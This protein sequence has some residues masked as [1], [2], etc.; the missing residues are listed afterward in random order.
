[1]DA[2]KPTIRRYVLRAV[3]SALLASCALGS[4]IAAAQSPGGDSLPPGLVRQG[5][6][7]M[8]APIADSGETAQA[9]TGSE[10]RESLAR[11]LTPADHALYAR[12]FD[13][14]D[15]GD[16]VAARGLAYE[17]HDPVAGQLIQWRYLIDKNSGA[18][19]GEIAAFLKNN[20]DWPNRDTL[21]ARAE[22]AMDPNMEPHAVVAWFGDRGPV[23]DIGKIRL[24][25]ALS[26]TGSSVRGRELVQEGW[27]DGDFEPDQEFLVIQRDGSV[28]TPDVDRQRLARLISRNDVSSARR[29]LAR[30]AADDQKIAVARLALRSNPTSGQHVLDT[31]SVSAKDDPGLIFD[32]TRL[33][34][35]QYN[36][37]QV[38][39]LLVR[40]PIRE[41]AK[42]NP[43]G[44]WKELDLD[45]RQAL[46][47][48]SYTTAY[49]I[50]SHT[51][52]TAD[53]GTNFSESEFLA[54]WIA[55]RFLKDPSSALSHFKA[56]ATAV[57]RP[58]SRARAHYWEGRSYEAMDDFS[59]AWREY[60]I[61]SETPEVFYGQLAF[62]RIATD[63]ALHVPEQA[64]DVSAVQPAYEREPLTRAIRV[65]ADLGEENLLR[66]FAV[67]DATIY[68]DPRHI[69]LLAEDLVRMGFREVAVR[70]AKTASYSNV[71][72]PAYSHPIIA[73]P[74]YRGPGLA[75]DTALVLGI[76]R[77]ETE[78]D[79]AAVSSAG[80]RGIIQVMPGSVRRF[81]NLGGLPYR[82]NDL[83]SDPDYD[84]QL[85]MTELAGELSDWGGSYVLAI[86]AYNAGPNNVRR[87]IAQF[88]DPRDA[89]VDPVDWIEEIPFYETRN[90]VQRVL[91]NTEVYRSRLA[92]RDQKLQI[93][94]DI[95]RPD[96]VQ[97]KPLLYMPPLPSLAVPTPEPK[98]ESSGATSGA[99]LQSGSPVS[100]AAANAAA[101]PTPA[102][103]PA[104]V[105]PKTNPER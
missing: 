40:A 39:K 95:Y 72:L 82:P 26:A 102:T 75:P 74:A 41:M 57:T 24:G 84:L 51:G 13:A 90:Y 37:D 96:A 28:L 89:R 34:R 79:P 47:M 15:R 68:N 6:V 86:A 35:Q 85:G 76:I 80:A 62:A 31:L 92:G 66:D 7:V 65:L 69:K 21:F 83:T 52:L 48:N 59:S 98:P 5:N 27:I 18:S 105:V 36:T 38:P 30:V 63:P 60:K 20:P 77:Q 61:A 42:V 101:E 55:L 73:I 94:A 50:A 44:W 88:G 53:D 93:L 71:A 58:I 10:R 99:E 70:V 56:I 2:R 16:W 67:G 54:G 4:G 103:E 46:Q 8:M 9:Y 97:S 32:Q 12:A 1:M 91:E 100:Q 33:L 29:E 17:G 104:Q 3:R 14:A 45:V 49:T 87:W 23:S 19:F 81:A 25:E 43:S 64:I 11:V 78:F 22:R